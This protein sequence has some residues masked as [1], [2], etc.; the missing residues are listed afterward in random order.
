[1]T[2]D[3]LQQ[4]SHCTRTPLTRWRLPWGIYA[5]R[6]IQGSG[7]LS[8]KHQGNGMGLLLFH[9]KVWVYSLRYQRRSGK[10][11]NIILQFFIA[12]CFFYIPNPF[13]LKGHGTPSYY[14]IFKRTISDKEP[15]EYREYQDGWKLS[16][17]VYNV[18]LNASF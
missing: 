1:M 10:R 12:V 8:L 5:C 15:M 13:L 17:R 3:P 11:Q 6:I 4:L 9:L 14:S 18:Y 2:S 7:A 16:K